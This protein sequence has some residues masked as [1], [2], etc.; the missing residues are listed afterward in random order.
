MGGYG[1]PSPPMLGD[2][3][4]D[5]AGDFG[6]GMPGA[7]TTFLNEENIRKFGSLDPGVWG[8]RD[9]RMLRHRRLNHRARIVEPLDADVV[10]RHPPMHGGVRSRL[11]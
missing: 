4:Q 9:T 2:L 7:P 5:E 8:R 10:E 3:M 1:M 11:C 6:Q